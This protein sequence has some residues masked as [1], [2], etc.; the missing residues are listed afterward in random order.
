MAQATSGEITCSDWLRRVTCRSVRFRIGAVRITV[1]SAILFSNEQRKETCDCD[2]GANYESVNHY[3]LFCPRHAAH[4]S[5]LLLAVAEIFGDSWYH[6]SDSVKAKIFLFGSDKLTLNQNNT[7]FFHV[8][9]YI[10]SEI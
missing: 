5:S 8:Q 2:C 9:Q 3:L 10:K 1:L 4:R 6:M 7:I